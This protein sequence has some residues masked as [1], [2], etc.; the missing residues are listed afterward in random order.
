M[1]F[2]VVQ[3]LRRDA[4]EHHCFRN[5]QY[6]INHLSHHVLSLHDF[7]GPE[8]VIRAM[9]DKEASI[10]RPIHL[11]SM[12]SPKEIMEWDWKQ[13]LGNNHA[14]RYPDY[15]LTFFSNQ[16]AAHGATAT[17]EHYIFSREANEGETLTL[18]RFTSRLLHPLIQAGFGIEFGQDFMVAQGIAQAAVCFPDASN[19]MDK[20]HN[21]PAIISGPECSLLS[22]LRDV[23]DSPSL[24]PLP[25][26][27]PS[28]D[29]DR[30]V[31]WMSMDPKRDA[32]LRSIYS[33]WSFDLTLIRR[34]DRVS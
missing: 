15:L 31:E 12:S 10:Q 21:T 1:D 2:L 25:Y 6:F 4:K 22:L 26:E 24:V 19:M 34:W 13:S 28:T 32:A 3:P 30:F 14:Q 8:A 29:A 20:P 7:G 33:Q 27:G 18:A 16:V 5:E 23:Y 9:N 17:L 11:N